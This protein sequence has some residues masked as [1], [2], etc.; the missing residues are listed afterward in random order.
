ME[1][2]PAPSTDNV[3]EL[4]SQLRTGLVELYGSRLKGVFLY[5]S[6]ARGMADQGSDVDVLIVLDHIGRYGHEINRT[7]NLV[8]SLSLH[9]G[10]SISRVFVS[11]DDWASRDTPFLANVRGEAVPA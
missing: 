8:S 10:L 7:S 5:G 2:R 9:Y 11:H 4:M 3:R 6:H 1:V